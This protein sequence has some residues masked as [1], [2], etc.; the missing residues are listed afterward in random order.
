MRR[1]R[2]TIDLVKVMQPS[3]AT[4]VRPIIVKIALEALGNISH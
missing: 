2:S 4:A 1:R 3:N